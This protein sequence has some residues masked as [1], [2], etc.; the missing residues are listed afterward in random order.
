MA[1]KQELGKKLSCDVYRA[2]EKDPE[3]PISFTTVTAKLR[4][5]TDYARDRKVF[6]NSKTKAYVQHMEELAPCTLT[7]DHM[8]DLQNIG[9]RNISNIE[10]DRVLAC[11][12]SKD[13]VIHRGVTLERDLKKKKNK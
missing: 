10:L 7:G 6:I 8:P 2:V 13:P 5:A 9:W 4:Y 1:K 3:V 12:P 11:G